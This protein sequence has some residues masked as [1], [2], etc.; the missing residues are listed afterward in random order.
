MKKYLIIDKNTMSRES[1]AS[2]IYQIEEESVVYEAESLNEANSISNFY[3]AIDIV[4]FNPGHH[5][6]S[7]SSRLQSLKAMLNGANILV[8]TNHPEYEHIENL[9]RTGASSVISINSG[10]NEVETAIRSLKTGQSY[11]SQNL[12]VVNKNINGNKNIKDISNNVAF[13][14]KEEDEATL[15]RRQKQVLDCIIKGYANKLIAYELGVSEGTIKLHVSSIL[16]ALNVTNR[17]EAA[18]RGGQ[19]LHSA[20]H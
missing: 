12:L 2:L 11:V 1:I 7:Q 17:T 15:T 18:L 9:L 5:K 16:R 8:I 13:K 4:V 19:F 14:G 20:A 3:K 10:R 6:D